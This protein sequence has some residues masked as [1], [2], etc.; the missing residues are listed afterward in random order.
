MFM[1]CLVIVNLQISLLKVNLFHLV[2][3]GSTL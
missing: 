1:V 2:V 3:F